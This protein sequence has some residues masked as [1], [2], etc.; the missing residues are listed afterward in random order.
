MSP[1]RTSAWRLAPFAAAVLLAAA[2]S[3]M[4]SH[5][6]E[7]KKVDFEQV[8]DDAAATLRDLNATNRPTFQDKLRALKDKKGWSTEQF[9]TEAT[10][11]VQDDKINEYDQ[12]SADLLARINSMGAEGSAAATPD[13]TLLGE[14]KAAMKDLIAAQRAKWT[15]MF[16]KLDAALAGP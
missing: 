16:G 2:G 8:V 11:Y 15:Y 3:P 7:C 12:T 4:Q 14:V 9:L 13:C 1:A 5:A 10:T 6:Q